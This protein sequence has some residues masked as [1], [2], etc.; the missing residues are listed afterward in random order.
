[1][2]LPVIRTL[3]STHSLAELQAAE[4]ALLEGETLPMEVPGDDEGEQ[5]TH[6]MGAQH[7]VQCVEQG[8]DF[9]AALRDFTTRVRNCLN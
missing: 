7:V 6:I 9:G 1:M 8:M 2:K 3:A 4:T 5:L